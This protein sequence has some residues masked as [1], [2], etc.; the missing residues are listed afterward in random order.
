MTLTSI[1]E[2]GANAITKYKL[3]QDFPDTGNA[4]INSQVVPLLVACS[5]LAWPY[6]VRAV[7]ILYN[8]YREQQEREFAEQFAL[9]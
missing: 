6:L 2:Q 3:L 7:E 4:S 1:V 8:N 5:I 9:I